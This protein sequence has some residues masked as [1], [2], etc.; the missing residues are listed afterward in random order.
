MAQKLIL[1]VTTN[2][3]H[4]WKT[5]M[6]TTA[7][8]VFLRQFKCPWWEDWKEVIKWENMSGNMVTLGPKQSPDMGME[9]GSEVHIQL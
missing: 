8:N 2:N 5:V 4:S 1:L 9:L 7:G 3:V 6:E